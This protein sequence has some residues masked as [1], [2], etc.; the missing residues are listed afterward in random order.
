MKFQHSHQLQQLKKLDLQ[1]HDQ[2]QGLLDN[3]LPA[4]AASII[5]KAMR[6]AMA[7]LNDPKAQIWLAVKAAIEGQ[8]ITVVVTGYEQT[9]YDDGCYRATITRDRDD[10]LRLFV[11]KSGIPINTRSVQVGFW[12]RDWNATS[13]AFAGQWKLCDGAKQA[14][15]RCLNPQPVYRKYGEMR[16]RGW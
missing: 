1:A 11:R 9:V 14:V 12:G 10:R 15:D 8:Q 4:L 13:G 7:R 6:A 5:V 3:G 16:G 2:A